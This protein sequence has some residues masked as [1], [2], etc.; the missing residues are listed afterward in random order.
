MEEG[1]KLIPKFIS[2]PQFNGKLENW[3]DFQ[4]KFRRA[5]RS[6]SA[7][8]HNCMSQVEGQETVVDD[9]LDVNV[10][11]E[12]SATFFD[13][14]C[15]HV[16]G[17]ALMVIKSVEGFHG[18][19][20]WRRL[21]RKYS[22][23]TLARRLRLLMAVVNPGRVKNAGEIQAGLTLWEGKVKQL[24]DQFEDKLSDQMKAAIITSAMPNKVQDHI[25]SACSGG[26][27]KSKDPTFEETKETI[28]LYAS[29]MENFNAKAWHNE[30][31]MDFLIRI[32]FLIKKKKSLLFFCV[33]FVSESKLVAC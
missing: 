12:T 28:L 14:L 15:Q 23:R 10:S 17:E 33:F 8:A 19:E 5:I 1:T 11:K 2:C 21:H 31:R 27:G 26:I 22:P 4:F 6:Q 24:N 16:E 30:K 20:A 32:F 13:I 18:F 3:E 9:D 25:L 29:R 7:S